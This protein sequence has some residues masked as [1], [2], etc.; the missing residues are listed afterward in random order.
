MIF[1]LLQ[2]FGQFSKLEALFQIIA[3]SAKVSD[4]DLNALS[5]IL[6]FSV[7]IF[8]YFS[9]L[10]HSHFAYH[11]EDDSEDDELGIT[12]LC[13]P[14]SYKVKILLNWFFLA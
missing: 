2:S 5:H 3:G 13:W 7:N 6:L 14:P 1:F 12:D 4:K 10:C 11:A 9:T 8:E